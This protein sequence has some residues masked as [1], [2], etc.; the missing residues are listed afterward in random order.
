MSQR[1]VALLR[2]INVGGKNALP[3]RELVAL[4]EKSGGRQVETYIQ[5]GNVAFAATAA[6]AKGMASAITRGI[7]VRYGY[8]VPVVVRSA[9]ELANV[10]A[11][12]PY[13]SSKKVDPKSLHV[14]FLAERP[15]AEAIASLDPMR[16]PPD[17]FHVIDREIYLRCPNG[18]G[19]SKLTN[20]YFDR[21]LGTVSTL[22][23]WATV[24]RLA[25]MCAADKAK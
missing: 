13:A 25:E 23:N 8:G 11:S 10:L 18:L 24:Q 21:T 1:F 4:V 20:A 15:K 6:H 16:S 14:A 12:N 7:A 19:R 17:A 3:M 9:A 22:R 5:S 2:G